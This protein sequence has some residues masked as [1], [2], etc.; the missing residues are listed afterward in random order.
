MGKDYTV[1]VHFVDSHGSMFFQA[2]HT[3]SVPTSV[4]SGRVQYTKTIV[5]PTTVPEGDYRILV[6]LYDPR[7]AKTGWDKQVLKAGK[8]VT[9][10]GDP[11]GKGEYQIGILKV[12]STAPIPKLPPRTLDLK[13]YKLTFNEEFNDLSVSSKG[14]ATRWIAHTPYFGDFGDARFTDP[15]EGFPFTIENGKLRIEARKTENGWQAGLLSSADPQGNGFSQKFGYF[16]MRAKFPKGLGVWP[17]FWLM[18][19][20]GIKDKT[21][22]NPEIDVV[23]HYGVMPNALMMTMHFWGPGEK[24]TAEGE[25]AVVAGMSDDFHTYGVLVEE[26]STIWYFDGVELWRQKTAEAAK[27]PLYIM[28]NLAMGGGWPIDKAV[29]PSYMY[30][31]YVKAYA[32]RP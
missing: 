26:S 24:H 27:V 3:P 7:A 8:D 25:A 28:V 31:D 2:D 14:P 10:V 11:G 1:S 19:V 18:G 20:R 32:K 6:G 17:A 21:V 13:G 23:E 5:V 4:W 9:Y 29:S 15:Q 12:S 22:S 16:E 30:V